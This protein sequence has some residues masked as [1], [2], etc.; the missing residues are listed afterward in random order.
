LGIYGLLRALSFLDS[1][2]AWW[3]LLLISVGLSSAIF[4]VLSALAQHDL[5]RLLAY[6]SVEN[7]GIIALGIGVGL[8]GVSQGSTPVALLGF[9]GALLHVLN[10][11][12]FKGLLF[13][14]AGAVRQATGELGMDRLGGLLKRMPI[15]GGTFLVGAAAISGLP[16]LN[17]FVS[18]FLILLGAF[19][20]MAGPGVFGAVP[21]IAVV[22]GLGLIGGL[23]VACFTKA[24]GV[25]FLG[26]PRRELAR[27]AQ[28]V[29][30]GMWVPMLVLAALCVASGVLPSLVVRLLGPAVGQLSG[31]SPGAVAA[32]LGP[33][34]Q[35]LISV[36]LVALIV[37]GV[38]AALAVLR[39]VLLARRVVRREVTW[40]C[41][42][43][44]PS[45]RMQYT[46]TSYVQPL[47]YLFRHLLR[48]RQW[49]CAPVGH[50]PRRASFRSETADLF[51]D[52]LYRPFLAL[53]GW[54]SSR[55]LWLQ[56]GRIQLYLLYIFVA[57]ILVLV[58]GL[59]F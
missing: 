34:M 47:Q 32:E 57:L 2:P 33:A 14:G 59:G 42:Y 11:A 17:G 53:V 16:P 51:T 1:P 6:S 43:E 36:T 38:A 30:P 58:W 27:P 3:G 28:E 8:V 44:L 5:K 35:P 15:T 37:I 20:Q 10:H 22:V 7:I 24:F 46:A 12:L 23:A 4:G 39:A 56:Q 40:D 25:V 19:Q 52:N 26:T 55:M 45:P 54:S 48:T 49:L 31:L 29:G 13:L 21:L 50:F 41:G 9:A 18:E